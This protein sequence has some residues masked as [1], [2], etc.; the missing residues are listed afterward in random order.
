[1]LTRLTLMWGE[2]SPLCPESSNGLSGYLLFDGWARPE[3]MFY[4]QTW[5]EFTDIF[6]RQDTCGDLTGEA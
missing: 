2:G 5:M 3:H 6:I 4:E 1:M